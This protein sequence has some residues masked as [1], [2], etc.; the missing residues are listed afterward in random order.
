MTR[1]TPRTID[2]YL[3]DL[4][5]ALRGEDPALIQDALYDAEEHL[6]AEFAENPGVDPA[7]LL[8][9]I[10]TSYGAPD[11]VAEIYRDKEIVVERALRPPPPVP[12]TS[13]LGRFFGVATDPRAWSALF[14]MLLALPTGIFYFVWT[15]T[16]LSLSFGLMILIIGIPFAALFLAT[17]RALSL[18]EGRIVEVML[19]E[20]MPRRPLYVQRNVPFVER[21]KTMFT[22][23]RTW[24]TMLYMLLQLPLGIFYFVLFVTMLSVG[25]ALALNPIVYATVGF[26]LIDI[27]GQF[28]VPPLALMPFT[29]ALGIAMLFGLLHLARGI[30]KF[31]GALA[32]SL[33]VPAG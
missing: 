31:Q 33:L 7:E 2:E 18:V 14:Y 16:G 25:L 32:K 9:K 26:G 27:N 11:E 20:R 30:A 21:V 12:R 19:G 10:S 5:A 1:P 17:V 23:P 29:I 8:A 22:D 4:R 6:R 3:D 13:A 24:S 28:W 15:V